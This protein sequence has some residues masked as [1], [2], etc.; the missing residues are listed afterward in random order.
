[1]VEVCCFE[2]EN[3][4]VRLVAS[5][6]DVLACLLCIKIG[7]CDVSS[8]TSPSLKVGEISFLLL[9]ARAARRRMTNAGC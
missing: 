1:M 8:K 2:N 6:F 7:V 4:F 5:S 3:E 9:A